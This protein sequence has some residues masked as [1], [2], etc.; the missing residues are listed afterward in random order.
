MSRLVEVNDFVC[1]GP[2]VRITIRI[3]TDTKETFLRESARPGTPYQTLINNVLRR[4][5]AAW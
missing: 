5:S 4:A 3:R 1:I 2:S